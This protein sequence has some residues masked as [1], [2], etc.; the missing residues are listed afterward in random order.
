MM[1]LI[2]NLALGKQRQISEFAA[3][4]VYIESSSKYSQSYVDRSYLKTKLKWFVFA[5]LFLE[6]V[7]GC[8]KCRRNLGDL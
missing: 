3:S 7:F 8:Y 5:Y 6:S 1:M 4:L 2:C